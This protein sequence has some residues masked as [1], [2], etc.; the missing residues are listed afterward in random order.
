MKLP[1]VA[2]VCALSVTSAVAQTQEVRVECKVTQVTSGSIYIDA[3]RDQGLMAGDRVVF[4]DANGVTSEGLVRSTSK[5]SARVELLPG[6]PSV[7]LNARAEVRIPAERAP[8]SDGLPPHPGWSQPQDGWAADKPLL[9]P[10]T[11]LKPGERERVW[12]GR[13]WSRFDTDLS[14][15]TDAGDSTYNYFAVGGDASL[16][17]PFGQGGS[18]RIDAEAIAKLRDT[19]ADNE[20]ESY[21][22]IDRLY[23]EFGGTREE[24]TRWQMGRFYSGV[25]PQLGLLDGVEY[26]HRSGGNVFGGSLGW[27]P[28]PTSERD[29]FVDL[30]AN[31]FWKQEFD[32]QRRNTLGLALQQTLHDGTKDRSLILADGETRIGEDLTL[33]GS[34]W[35]D[36]YDG[37][38]DLKDSSWELTELRLSALYRRSAD[39]GMGLSYARILWPQLLRNEY[40][41]VSNDLVQNGELNRVSAWAWQQWNTTWRTDE[42]LDSWSDQDDSGVS[43]EFETSAQDWAWDAGR[44]ALALTY[45]DGSYSSG[46][47]VRVSADRQYDEVYASV[48]WTW[49]QYEEK[50][51]TEDDNPFAQHMLHGS[52]DW[53]LSEAWDLSLRADRR[54]DDVVDVWSFGAMLSTRF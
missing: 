17:N 54:F 2:M 4:L 51:W 48:G 9:A 16:R 35:I 20:S 27:L 31:V 30:A 45:A 42:R 22:S 37:D 14:T 12:T 32:E 28:E 10:V 38:D 52:V 24:P 1:Y 13:L 11:G 7:E 15:S 19:G 47:G 39:D 3:G 53:S 26:S 8:K 33:R 23:Y 25:M 21:L 18:L 5:A 6:S 29:S 43:W 34:L 40:A 41:P 44:V 36:L 49:S 50:D 46:P